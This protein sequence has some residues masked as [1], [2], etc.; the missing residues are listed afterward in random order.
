MQHKLSCQ[1]KKK[2]K[3]PVCRKNIKLL[4]AFGQDIINEKDLKDES[5]DVLSLPAIKI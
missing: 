1:E 4:D 5:D 3:W 2:P